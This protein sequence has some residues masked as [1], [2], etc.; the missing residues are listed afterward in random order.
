MRILYICSYYKPAYIYGGPARSIAAMCE[1]LSRQGAQVTVLTTNA[2]GSTPLDVPLGQP[3]DVDGVTVYYYPTAGGLPRRFFYSPSLARACEGMIRQYDIVV[4][5]TFFT[6]PTTPAVKA[7]RKWG[8]PYIIPQRGQLLP[9]ALKQKPLKK[10][11][12]LALAGRSYLNH[13]AGL[14]CSNAVELEAV[15]KLNFKAPAFVIPNGL[16]TAQWRNLPPRG[17]LRRQLAIPETAPLLLMLGRLHRVK[18]PDLAVEMLGLLKRRDVHLVFAGPDEEGFEPRLRARAFALGCGSRVHFTGLLSGDSLLRAMS[19]A[20]LFL[21]PSVME[22]FGMAAVE[23]MACGLP[24]LL[25]EH[26]PVGRWVE[27]AGAGR[28]VPC[29]AEAF[30]QACDDMLSDD[31]SLKEMGKQAR[32]LAFERF[33]INMVARQMLA[34]CESILLQGK[35]LLNFQPA[36]V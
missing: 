36:E 29:T 16:D 13:A 35:P 21:M 26:V 4:L 22:S 3:V 28:Q 5:E 17:A 23:A 11:A 18:N 8:K 33:D 32:A 24:V 9:W 25:S 1:A 30:L 2:N 15:Q 12:Y 10:Y 6:H 20:D 27:A 34:Q 7:C 14:L 19:D 31:K